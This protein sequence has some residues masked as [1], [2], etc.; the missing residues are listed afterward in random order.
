MLQ[1]AGLFSFVTAVKIGARLWRDVLA[2]KPEKPC[3]YCEF[4]TFLMCK[5]Y[6]FSL[7]FRRIYSVSIACLS[8]Q[9]R[10]DLGS[11]DGSFSDV[12]GDCFRIE[13]S[14]PRRIM[15]SAPK[16]LRR[17]LFSIL[18][19]HPAAIE[20]D[21]WFEPKFSRIR[22]PQ[23]AVETV[24]MRRKWG[25]KTLQK[26]YSFQSQIVRTKEGQ[27]VHILFLIHPKLLF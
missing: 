3:K 23:Q 17:A 27:T 19:Q 1:Y 16:Y 12:A 2:R 15:R 5:S 6:V 21:P 9:S 22:L 26:L 25:I 10:P 18:W 11:S 13:K 4:A 20:N 8:T 7:H 14:A 24:F